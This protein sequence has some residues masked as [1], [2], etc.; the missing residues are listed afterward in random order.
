MIEQLPTSREAARQTGTTRYFTGEACK[1]GHVAPRATAS[2]S[3]VTCTSIASKRWVAQ[4]APERL[5][6]YAADYRKRQET[7]EPAVGVERVNRKDVEQELR[8]K[9]GDRLKL[10]DGPIGYTRKVQFVCAT[11]G[12]FN[13]WL[14]N[15]RKNNGC[16]QCSFEAQ[17]LTQ[18][19]FLNKAAQIHGDTYDYSK[20][21]Y[22][23]A[24][25]KVTITCKKHGDF[26]QTPNK[27][28][29]GQGC[30]SCGAIDPKWERELFDY[31]Y[32]LGFDIKRNAPVLGRKHIDIFLPEY[33]FGIELHGLNWHTE[34]YHGKDYH[35]EKWEVAS[36]K[37]IRLIQIFADEWRDKKEIILRRLDAMLGIG[38]KFDAR[39]CAVEL[40]VVTEARAF[41]DTTHIQG[42]GAAQMYYG[43]RHDGNLV[44]VA[45]F[46]KAR[47]A[48]MTGTA[49][50]GW[51][52]I[53]YASVG[54]VRG[55][56]GK[57]FK[58]FVE[59]VKPEHVVSYCDLRYGDGKLYAATGFTLDS[60]TPPDYWWV[61]DGRVE[62]IPR[63]ATQKHKL[64][65]HPVLGK[66][67]APGKTEAQVCAEAGWS[68]L[69]GV[70]HQRW[71]WR[72]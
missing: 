12:A 26:Q 30:P 25:Q 48:S 36:A 69:F 24:M 27:H 72:P 29:N 37:G 43:L 44:A 22:V 57:L 50:S 47:A 71:V 65:T 3:C 32:A 34:Q 64:P 9:F 68:K 59:D 16:A 49:E 56:F 63:Y 20:T 35:R 5:A 60:I 33:Q 58:R 8:A 46:G 55:G 52:V 66:F 45:S 41:L 42:A 62:R 61:P 2:G 14:I 39:K 51:E 7:G 15:V 19:Q 11:H 28:L 67:Y 54:R 4:Q 17:R 53:R 21:Q 18:E 10:G 70:G 1:Q 23:T 40:L 13:A 38:S 6:K 31:L